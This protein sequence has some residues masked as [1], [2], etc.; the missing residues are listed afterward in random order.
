MLALIIVLGA[1]IS[2]L[3]LRTIIRN[4]EENRPQVQVSQLEQGDEWGVASTWSYLTEQYGVPLAQY[5]VSV[6]YSVYLRLS[7]YSVVC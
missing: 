7:V 6:T 3:R 5:I 4:D 1:V 2:A